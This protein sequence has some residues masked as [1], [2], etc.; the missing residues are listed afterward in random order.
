MTEKATG[1]VVLD[2]ALGPKTIEVAA[3]DLYGPKGFHVRVDR[4]GTLYLG[5]NRFSR[6]TFD[7]LGKA[8]V[9]GSTGR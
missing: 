1:R 7:S 8:F 5:T 2:A 6:N 9:V 3:A 4:D